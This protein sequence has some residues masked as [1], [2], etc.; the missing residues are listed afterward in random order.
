MK[1]S[2]LI[3]ALRE[4]NPD[5]PVDVVCDDGSSYTGWEIVRVLPFEDSSGKTV[6]ASIE[7][8]DAVKQ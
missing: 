5:T 7:I 8:V 3:S 4:Y 6:S 2:E 1:I